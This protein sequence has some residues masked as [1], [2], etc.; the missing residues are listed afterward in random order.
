MIHY[1]GNKH[2][3]GCLHVAKN[4][5]EC[6]LDMVRKVIEPTYDDPIC[7]Y[8]EHLADNLEPIDYE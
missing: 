5:V 1:Y 8:C 6:D 7:H 4:D 3:I 2:C